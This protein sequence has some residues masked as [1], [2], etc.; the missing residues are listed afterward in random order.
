[1]TLGHVFEVSQSSCATLNFTWHTMMTS[2]HEF[3]QKQV[4]LDVML[5]GYEM[6]EVTSH[7][8]RHSQFWVSNFV[9]GYCTVA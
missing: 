5:P 7:C 2:S 3:T 4:H 6:S 1:M 8:L 9:Q